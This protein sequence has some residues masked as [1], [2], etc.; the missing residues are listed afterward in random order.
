M[1]L[2]LCLP[3]LC[4][5]VNAR[6]EMRRTRNGPRIGV[7]SAWTSWLRG[8]ALIVQSQRRG[9]MF[10]GAVEV[11]IIARREN[12]RADLDNILKGTI[13]AL[14]HG[15]VVLND[16]QVMSLRASWRTGGPEGVTITVTEF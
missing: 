6:H 13:D 12:N 14:Q 7:S 11:E 8:A 2:C 10:K 9:T 3:V 5:S 4:P 15:G 1:N 16:S